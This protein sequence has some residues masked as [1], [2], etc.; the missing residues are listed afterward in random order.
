MNSII[1]SLKWCSNCLMMSTRPRISFDKRGYCNACT[2]AEKKRKINW[3]DREKKLKNLLKKYRKKNYFD[4]IATVSGGKD[5]SYVAYNLKHKYNM[6]PLCITI[7]PPLSR[8]LGQKN[9][10]SF[11][12]SGYDHLSLNI[13]PDVMRKMNKYGFMNYGFPYY[14]WLLSVYTSVIRIAQSMNI[15]L[16]FYSENGEVEYGGMK[17]EKNKHL[18]DI[19]YQKKAFL[20]GHYQNLLDKCKMSKKDKFFFTFPSSHELKKNP[21]K[22]THWSHYENWDPYRNYLIAKNK[23]GLQE[24]ELSNEGTF[25]NFAQTDQGLYPL[26][27]YLMYLKYGFGRATQDACIEI[28]R[29]AMDREQAKNLVQLYDNYFPE[30][31]VEEYLNY[32]Q[33]SLKQFEKTLD[34]FVNKKLFTKKNNRWEPQFEII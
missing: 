25:T 11:I 14:G 28:R 12:D 1:K 31:L 17:E 15:E 4:C 19:G 7:T 29:G 18:F 6:N 5:G 32:Y 23:C 34:K 33:I 27:T 30:S 22:F 8:E 13:N 2:W 26:H 20:A 10:K 16:I 21:V 24:S 3:L 9:L